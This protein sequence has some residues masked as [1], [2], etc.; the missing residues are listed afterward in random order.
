MV[1]RG[2]LVD[3]PGCRL[4]KIWTH[5]KNLACLQSAKRLNSHQIL[6]A[7][8]LGCFHLILTYQPGSNKT[9][10]DLLSCQFSADQSDSEPESIIPSSCV[11][12]TVTWQVEERVREAQCTMSTSSK[13]PI[14]PGRCPFQGLAVGSYIQTRISP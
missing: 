1:E 2:G 5:H 9:K 10:P 12:G 14:C 7:L 13:R 4:L 11:V 6:W 3:F 8:F